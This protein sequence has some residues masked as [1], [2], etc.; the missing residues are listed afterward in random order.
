MNMWQKLGVALWTRSNRFT[1]SFLLLAQQY[2]QGPQQVHLMVT[3]NPT[4]M[5]VMWVTREKVR[6]SS[7]TLTLGGHFAGPVRVEPGLP[8]R[9]CNWLNHHVQRWHTWRSPQTSFSRAS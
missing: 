6:F 1:A 4:E 9:R 3:R 2:V 7:F 8:G 5:V